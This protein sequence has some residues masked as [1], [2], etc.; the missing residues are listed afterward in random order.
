MQ[1]AVRDYLRDFEF[2]LSLAINN[3]IQPYLSARK[4]KLYTK[5]RLVLSKKTNLTKPQLKFPII[6]YIFLFVFQN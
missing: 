2:L 6:I 3:L 4:T 5:K 1:I